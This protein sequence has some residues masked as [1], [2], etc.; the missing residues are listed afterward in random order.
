MCCKLHLHI[1]HFSK[2]MI[3]A[4]LYESVFATAVEFVVVVVIDVSSSTDLSDHRYMLPHVC[5]ESRSCS[6]T[7]VSLAFYFN[8]FARNVSNCFVI[9]DRSFP[10]QRNEWVLAITV[11]VSCYLW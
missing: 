6:G 4:S 2:W 3:S 1:R 9:F 8:P 10:S 7:G 5:G 11:A